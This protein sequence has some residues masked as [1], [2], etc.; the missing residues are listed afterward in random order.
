MDKYTRHWT[1][2]HSLYL[3]ALAVLKQ[4]FN[5][6]F[7]KVKQDRPMLVIANHVTTWDP[8]FVALSFSEKPLYFVAS[9]HL[10][11]TPF[12]AGL[13]NTLVEPIARKKG[14]IGTDTVKACLRHLKEGRSVCIFAEG[15]ATWDGKS[16]KI[17]PATGKLAKISGASLLTYRIEGGYYSLPRWAEQSRKGKVY[18]HPVKLYS[19]EELKSMTASQVVDAINR[20]I[21][22]DA[23]ARQQEWHVA[24]E[25]D[26]AAEHLETALF[27]CPRC[28]Q[29]STLHSEGDKL[30]CVCG[31]SWHLTKV[32]CLEPEEPFRTI[33]DWD[34]WQLEEL[35]KM[36][37]DPEKPWFSDSGL[38]LKELE[39][40]HQEQEVGCGLM[41]QYADR[42][43]ICDR[44]FMLKD[45]SNMAM[46]KRNTILFTANDRYYQVR[47]ETKANLRKYLAVWQNSTKQ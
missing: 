9:E 46:L 47:S 16:G 10:M 19:P 6:S 26:C 13:L 5:Y 41:V 25:S 32:G 31:A 35:K 39:K 20:D 11:R 36:E 45:I 34:A 44:E 38:V 8:L 2:W 3:P 22:E 33:A 29:I 28:R 21:Y 4:K 27:L 40:N 15:D 14:S 12:V 1:V 23:D 30:Q 17:F 43:R 37:F 42:L 24:Y 18:G 7:E